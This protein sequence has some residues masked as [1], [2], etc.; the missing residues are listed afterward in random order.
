M[1]YQYIEYWNVY[2]VGNKSPITSLLL[3]E[4]KYKHNF[5][6]WTLPRIQHYVY[7][8]LGEKRSF[9]N[10]F[11]AKSH[12]GDTSHHCT[13]G[14]DSVICAPLFLTARL[15][16]RLISLPFPPRHPIERTKCLQGPR[17]R[18][19][20]ACAFCCPIAVPLRLCGVN[21]NA[22]DLA[23]QGIWTF[24]D[25]SKNKCLSICLL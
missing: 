2:L 9:V 10:I 6:S 21:W 1:Y 18:S 19:A 22:L 5:V 3:F 4:R 13:G 7:S 14:N 16:R 8:L 20:A 11:R 17:P 12:F 25:N 23:F 24:Q 15:R